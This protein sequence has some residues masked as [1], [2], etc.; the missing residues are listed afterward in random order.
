MSAQRYILKAKAGTHR[1]KPEGPGDPGKLVEQGEPFTPTEDELQHFGH[2]F[3]PYVN[4]RGGRD[5]EEEREEPLTEKDN[6][7][8]AEPKRRGRKPNRK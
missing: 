2:K 7:V 3:E 6:P 8:E 5:F 4:G 1:R